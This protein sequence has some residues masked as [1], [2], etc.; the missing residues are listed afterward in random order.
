MD[1]NPGAGARVLV[2]F[3][4]GFE[5]IELVTVVDV[6]RRA[7]LAVDLASVEGGI[8]CGSRGLRIES[9]GRLE[10]RRAKDYAALVLPGGM[11]NARRLAADRDAQRLVRE[12]AHD[13]RL[14][15]AICAAPLALHAAGQLEGRRFTS[16]PSVR[17]ELPRER[18]SEERVVLDGR[19]ITSRG[20]GTAMEFALALV[21]ELCGA[22]HAAAVAAPMV[23]G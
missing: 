2:L 4:E 11:K 6:L 1:A 5:E 9:E 10:G 13:G 14:I 23:V 17:D 20:P 19:L 15:A 18:Y 12:A 8:V 16:H 7:G 3:A 22:G 21:Q